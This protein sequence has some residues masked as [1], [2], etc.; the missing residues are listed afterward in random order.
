MP[1]LSIV[2]DLLRDPE[3][4]QRFVAK[5]IKVMKE[6]GLKP[7]EREILLTMDETKIK[8]KVPA[9]MHDEIDD[10]SF[11][12]D[13]FLPANG[14]FTVE[15]GGLEPNYPSPKPG[16]FR[17]RIN[18]PFSYVRAQE[19]DPAN[20]GQPIW[21]VR[22]GFSA[23]LVN[24]DATSK[25]IEV[26]VFGQSFTD[27]DLQLIRKRVNGT[28]DVRAQISHFCMMGTFRNSMVRAV[29]MPPV[30]NSGGSWIAGE[31]Y[32]VRIINQKG[33]DDATLKQTENASPLL[34][35]LP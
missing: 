25:P 20:P 32:Q 12:E 3:L 15:G 8:P 24:T 35:V 19:P 28:D 33:A 18:Y 1:L 34:V 7:R 27:V 16:I 29:F 30:G 22:R 23:A 4:R 26:T 21:V 10:F 14:D 11:D 2:E 17:Y 9:S 5:P 31:R 13:E 6:Y